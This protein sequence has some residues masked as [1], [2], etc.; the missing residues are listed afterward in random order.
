MLKQFG[1]TFSQRFP[2]EA[3]VWMCSLAL[4]LIF[5]PSG[6]HYSFCLFSNIGLTFC[7]GCGLGHAI[8]Y[9]FHGDLVASF[10]SHPMA[11]PVVAVLGYRI[12]TLVYQNNLKSN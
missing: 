4:L 8:S 7:P 2:L 9:L 6:N 12:I 5:E 11:I 10:N 1:Q 3:I